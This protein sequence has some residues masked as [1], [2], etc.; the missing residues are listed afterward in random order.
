MSGEL[1][2]PPIT[3]ALTYVRLCNE[4][5]HPEMPE[6]FNAYPDGDL[7]GAVGPDETERDLHAAQEKTLWSACDLLGRYFTVHARMAEV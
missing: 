7:Y 1:V 6:F 2:P 4:A 5:R 3:A